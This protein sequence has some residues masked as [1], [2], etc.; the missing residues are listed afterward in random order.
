MKRIGRS[1]VI[2]LL[3]LTRS[4]GPQLGAVTAL[5]QARL[6]ASPRDRHALSRSMNRTLP[7]G[8]SSTMFMNTKVGVPTSHRRPPPGRT[9]SGRSEKVGGEP[10]RPALLRGRRRKGPRPPKGP[11]WGRRGHTPVVRVTAAGTKRVSTAALICTNSGHRP[12]LIY[13]IHLDRGPAKGLAR[14]SPRPTTHT[15]WMLHASN[16]ATR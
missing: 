9:S 4:S 6:A 10:G 11:T 3:A 12:R 14:A 13:R 8:H 2:A 7:V 1:F 16:S 15:Y 5:R